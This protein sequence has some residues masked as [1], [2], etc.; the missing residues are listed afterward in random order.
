MSHFYTFMS[1]SLRLDPGSETDWAIAPTAP[2]DVWRVIFPPLRKKGA[3]WEGISKWNLALPTLSC[4]PTAISTVI[5]VVRKMIPSSVSE[6]DLSCSMCCDIYT[7]PITLTCAHSICKVCLQQFWRTKESRECPVC[8]SKCLNLIYRINLDLKNLC[9]AFLQEKYQRQRLCS[10]H[11]LEFKFFC[12][13][14]QQLVCS[15]CQDSELHRTHAFSSISSVALKRR[16]RGL[17]KCPYSYSLIFTIL[18][19]L[20]EKDRTRIQEYK[21]CLLSFACYMLLYNNK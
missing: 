8:G 15:L 12:E 4:F 19:M 11:H 3:V 18:F 10:L 20:M 2:S 1:P 14:D 21:E 9:E 13:D 5:T 6:E 16:V 7:D 17:I